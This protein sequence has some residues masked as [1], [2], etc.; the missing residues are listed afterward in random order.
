VLFSLIIQVGAFFSPVTT[1][2][3]TPPTSSL[4]QE[5]KNAHSQREKDEQNLL[6]EFRRY[7]GAMM[8]PLVMPTKSEE[9][10]SN[11]MSVNEYDT[12]T[13]NRKVSSGQSGSNS[14]KRNTETNMFSPSGMF[15]PAVVR[16]IDDRSADKPA[17]AHLDETKPA[18]HNHNGI[19]GDEAERK[20]IAEED[21][22]Q[23]ETWAEDM[24]KEALKEKQQIDAALAEVKAKSKAVENEQKLQQE[25]ETFEGKVEAEVTKMMAQMV[26]E[27]RERTEPEAIRTTGMEQEKKFEGIPSKENAQSESMSKNKIEESLLENKNSEEIK[28]G[29][30]E[31][32]TKAEEEAKFDVSAVEKEG[33]KLEAIQVM[34]NQRKEQQA[35]LDKIEEELAQKIDNLSKR[36]EELSRLEDEMALAQQPTNKA[37]PHYSPK[38]YAALSP[39]E[40]QKL[41]EDRAAL[42]KIQKDKANTIHGDTSRNDVRS[43]NAVHPILGP[44]IAD[45]GYKRVHVVSSGRLGTIPIWKKQRTYRHDRVKRMAAEKTQKMHF[46]FPGIICLYEDAEGKLSIIDGQHRVGM[47]QALRESRNR[48]RKRQVGTDANGERAKIFEE[49]EKSFQNVLVEVYSKMSTGNATRTA[50]NGHVYAEEIFLDINKAEPIALTNLQGAAS[51]TESEIITEAVSTLRDMYSDLFSSSQKCRSPNVNVD[52]LRNS[53]FGSN[54]LKR[55]KE[56]TTAGKLSDWLLAQNAAVGEVYERDPERQRLVEPKAWSKATKNG[57]YL[58][59]ESSWLYK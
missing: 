43:K 34:V 53:I 46:G 58:G 57:F 25:V 27:D 9:P 59:L 10:M 55:N 11:F 48:R 41:K 30:Y 50:N 33:E 35:Q 44:V 15:R 8:R 28:V 56:L 45:L 38:E 6:D 5:E 51:E 2:K 18:A 23:V 16:T 19:D 42:T 31:S 26:E 4:K 1:T 40:K 7:E 3:S 29:F 14:L 17:P 32:K 36:K 24:A 39:E 47:M 21:K 49:E 13:L 20:R 12:T 37:I 22:K 54:L 52:N